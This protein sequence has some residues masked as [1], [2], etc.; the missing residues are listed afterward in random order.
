MNVKL[1]GKCGICLQP[2]HRGKCIDDLLRQIKALK[3]EVALLQ[4]TQT[5]SRPS[6]A[7]KSKAKQP[8]ASA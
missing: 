3:A 8:E 2:I 4:S 1:T 7:A 5:V 6:R